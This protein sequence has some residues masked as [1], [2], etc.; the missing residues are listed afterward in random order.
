MSLQD[1]LKQFQFFL[2]EKNIW[3][4]KDFL[5]K[6][7]TYF[8]TGGR[9]KF[10]CSPKDLDDLKQL[11]VFLKFNNLNYRV[12]GFTSNILLLDYV[13]YSIIISTKNLTKL[14][15][16]KTYIEV[17][18]GYS[19]QDFVRVISVL[20]QS[21]G[22]EGLE[23][24]PGSVGGAIFMNAGAYG[25][26]ISDHIISVTYISSEGEIMTL[27]KEECNFTHRGSIFRHMNDRIILNAKFNIIKGDRKEISNNIE[28]F[29]I[30]RHSY[31][32]FVYPNLG[33]IISIKGDIY[34]ELLYSNK[35]YMIK[36]R[37][38]EKLYK[39]S[40]VKL[41]KRRKPDNIVFNNLIQKCLGQFPI[42]PSKKS[43]NILVNRGETSI[44]EFFEYIMN[45]SD[46]LPEDIK[47]E[48]EFIFE[49][50]LTIQPEFAELHSKMKAKLISR[51]NQ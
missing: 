12:I 45:L 32:E 19:L 11:L 37:I 28:K 33:S 35:L 17:E 18:C 30:A 23:G 36:Y 51:N 42:E 21:I 26:N 1:R 7:E 25:C 27:N 14:F 47:I 38:L 9:V 8:K 6:Y 3:F 24:I 43:V 48:N 49:P 10:F 2:E 22:Y 16:S 40:L 44:E 46:R 41:L 31:Q 50:I 15:S 4:Q 13:E 29:H 5:I 20:N 39:N 34:R